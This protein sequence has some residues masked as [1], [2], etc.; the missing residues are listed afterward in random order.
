MATKNENK[1]IG[2]ETPTEA[3]ATPKMTVTQGLATLKLLDKRIQKA[4]KM[5][6][7]GFK[8]GS[9]V[10]DNF[11]EK[12]TKSKYDSLVDLIDYRSRL[13]MAINV[14]NIQTLVKIGG[15]DASVL[16]CIEHK[17]TL[18]YQAQFLKKLQREF[19]EATDK[20]EY[21]N[22]DVKERLDSQVRSAFEKATVKD[23]ESFTNTF[24]KNNKVSL[25]DPLDVQKLIERLDNEIDT[26]LNEVDFILSTSNATTTISV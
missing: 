25:V 7:L 26:F 11:D 12:D 14:S 1:T 13:K 10:Q 18:E 16:A 3:T 22:Q 23:I 2:T 19:S 17:T 5:K 6:T 20:V 8:I 9:Q 4:S 21:N 15:R 24:N